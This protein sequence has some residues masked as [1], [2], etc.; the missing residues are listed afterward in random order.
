MDGREELPGFWKLRRRGIGVGNYL[1]SLT[2]G[3]SDAAWCD[4][5]RLHLP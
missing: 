4:E 2:A 5:L 1:W 3:L